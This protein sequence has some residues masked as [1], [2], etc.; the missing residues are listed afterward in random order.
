MAARRAVRNETDADLVSRAVDSK[1]LES[2]KLQ[3]ELLRAWCSLLQ[4]SEP[5]TGQL[6]V[7]VGESSVVQVMPSIEHVMRAVKDL[8]NTP[9]VFVAGSLHLVGGFM[10]HLQ[11]QGVLDE[12]L[13][14]CS[15]K[16]A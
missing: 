1:D 8:N 3:Q 13:A 9:N 10:A 7:S 2:M 12:R 15:A 4:L 6:T 16:T 14:S 5:A 11:N